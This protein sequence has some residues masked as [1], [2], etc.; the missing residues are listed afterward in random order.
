MAENAH[1]ITIGLSA[2]LNA[3]IASW[4]KQF[5]YLP[6]LG[7]TKA[8]FDAVTSQVSF[9]HLLE[10]MASSP[11]DNFI[12]IIHGHEDGSG[13]WLKLALS[14]AKPHTTHHDLQRLIDLD[15][16]GAAM[17]RHD[18]S[19]M[20]IGSA[21]VGKILDL[22]HKVLAKRIGCIEFRSCNLGRN[23][24]SLDRFRQFFGARRAGAPDLHTVFGHVPILLGADLMKHHARYHTGAG[25]WETYNF[26]SALRSPTLVACFALNNLAK[27]EFGGH[28]AAESAI[29]LNQWIQHY[30]KKSASYASGNMAMHALWAAD[31]IVAPKT[32]GEKER[33]VPA[34]IIMEPE[35]ANEPLGGFGPP[36]GFRRLVLPLSENYAKHIVYSR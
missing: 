22:R 23:K 19:I 20:G 33:R 31:R 34:A 12:L 9:S 25:H 18:Y 15:A 13:L 1:V 14:Q 32:K 35:D 7:L 24:L 4:F 36:D 16:G 30:I 10:L 27:P 28:I 6:P 11:H 5:N 2:A 8:K 17:S 21:E 29:V 3:D 26:P